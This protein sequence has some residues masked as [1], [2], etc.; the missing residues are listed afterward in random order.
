[1]AR[2]SLLLTLLA[3]LP[4]AAGWTWSAEDGY[5]EDL[6]T[7]TPADPRTADEY[8][9]AGA[10]GTA[11][12]R[13]RVIATAAKDDPEVLRVALLKMSDAWL[14]G[15][16]WYEAWA[17]Y[18]IC[19]TY[20]E[21]HAERR[22]ARRF[23]VDALI[24]GVEEGASFD[25]F[26]TVRG[27]RWAENQ[28]KDLLNAYAYEDW[29]VSARLR[30]AQALLAADRYDHAVLEYEWLLTDYP[31]SPF[32]P[33][34]RYRKGEAL[35]SQYQGKSYDGEPLENARREFRRYLD[36][37]PEGDRVDAARARL[38]DTD[39][40]GAERD[41]TAYEH[42]RHLKRWRSAH[43]Y[44]RQVL[45]RYPGT[46]FAARAAEELAGVEDEVRALPEQKRSGR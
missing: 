23:Q 15:R 44:L 31:D 36:E 16:F 10:F 1:M 6:M 28:V 35:L 24:L 3:A 22:R 18:E 29:S 26:G 20:A 12:Q 19:A 42:Y 32:A 5:V 34:A 2:L 27:S 40:L 37:N 9:A 25:W 4:A 43:F 30:L 17:G 13:F 38:K 45:K 8:A 21:T 46:E 7:P 39:E 33:T 14:A 41:W 11:A